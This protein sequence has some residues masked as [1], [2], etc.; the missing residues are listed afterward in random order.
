MP[1]VIDHEDLAREGVA[2]LVARLAE[3]VAVKSP[4]EGHGILG[5][6]E[7]CVIVTVGDPLAIDEDLSARDVEDDAMIVALLQGYGF[8]G[9]NAGR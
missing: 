8:I 4:L 5:E 3:K 7:V 1:L 2:L 6:E 9:L